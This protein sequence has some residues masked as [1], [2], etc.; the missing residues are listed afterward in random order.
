MSIYTLKGDFGQTEGPSGRI[1]KNHGFIRAVGALDETQAAL[2]VVCELLG[3]GAKFRPDIEY[4]MQAL[5]S[6]ATALFKKEKCEYD[7][8]FL[9]QDLQDICDYIEKTL[10]PVTDFILPLGTLVSSHT[11]LARAITRRAE[12]E[13]V[14]YYNIEPFDKNILMFINRLS[15]SLFM[16]AR[17]YGFVAAV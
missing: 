17:Y 13:L 12:R 16:L 8:I 10:G 3:V 4:C 6:C 9:I 15:D 7:L 14:N 1:A 11:H 5:H 2:G